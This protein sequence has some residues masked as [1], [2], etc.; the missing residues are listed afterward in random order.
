MKTCKFRIWDR[1][2]SHFVGNEAG[3]H[4]YSQWMID[5]ETGKIFDA[6][7][8][9][10]VKNDERLLVEAQDYFMDGLKI[11]NKPRYVLQEATGLKD[12]KGIQ[13]FEGDI[14]KIRADNWDGLTEVY[15]NEKEGQW[16]VKAKKDA[17]KNSLAEC[18]T[19]GVTVVGNVFE[20][21]K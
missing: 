2:N 20:G 19:Y 11:V 9:I 10:G 7:G 12:K 8:Y 4:C 14:V 1:Q 21:A 15:W 17:V 16:W 6:V 18:K 13:I 5:V 3:T